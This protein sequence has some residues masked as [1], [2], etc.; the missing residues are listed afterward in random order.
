MRG[1]SPSISIATDGNDN[2]LA[3]FCDDDRVLID[4]LPVEDDA[5]IG[6]CSGG[7]ARTRRLD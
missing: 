4:A 7:F 6:D 1:C 5:L 2:G 3:A